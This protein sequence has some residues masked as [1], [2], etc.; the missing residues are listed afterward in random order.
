MENQKPDEQQKPWYESEEDRA[1]A[2]AVNSVKAAVEGGA[3]FDEAAAKIDLKDDALRAAAVSDALKVLIAEMHLIGKTPLDVLAA[4]LALP[5]ERLEQARKEMMADLE[6]AAIE[7][8]KESL[9]Q[10][11]NA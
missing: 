5:L 1:Y 9:G 4:K 3:P 6:A 11:G 10:E 7:K 8:Y 2:E